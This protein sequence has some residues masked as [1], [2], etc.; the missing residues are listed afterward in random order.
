[1]MS[2]DRIPENGLDWPGAVLLGRGPGA[3]GS[4]GWPRSGSLL[5]RCA[6]CGDVMEASRDDYFRCQ[7][8]AMSLDIDGGRFGSRHGDRNVLVYRKRSDGWVP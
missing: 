2:D 5:Y 8:G 6:A 7:C 1:M 3:A 4:V